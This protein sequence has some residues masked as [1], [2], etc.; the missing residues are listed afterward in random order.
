M[1]VLK[2]T[3]VS[4]RLQGDLGDARGYQAGDPK[5]GGGHGGSR[6]SGALL[7]PAVSQY[8]GLQRGRYHGFVSRVHSACKHSS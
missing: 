4:P 5:R 6:K 8:A 3:V 2:L 1:C 7:L